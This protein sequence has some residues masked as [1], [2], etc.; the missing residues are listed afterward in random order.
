[1]SFVLV[2]YYSVSLGLLLPN[3]FPVDVMIFT[4]VFELVA[5]SVLFA[6]TC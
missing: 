3:L 2:E 4:H 5:V 1:M 6:L